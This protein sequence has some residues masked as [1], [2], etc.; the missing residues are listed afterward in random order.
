MGLT[1]HMYE[2][3]KKR[4]KLK[5][6]PI[7]KYSLSEFREWFEGN[8][9][10]IYQEWIKSGM[11]P[12]IK[13]SVDRLSNDLP[14]KLSNMQVITK[15]ENFDKGVND[16]KRGVRQLDLEGVEI[17][18]H[19]SITEAAR[20]TGLLYGNIHKV[21]DGERHQTGGYNWEFI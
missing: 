1:G 16:R 9:K 15:K 17:A 13:P 7:P 5:G 4:S 10:N 2:R 12:E 8:G 6:W 18:I 3:I 11:K 19:P 20:N 14:Y 21:L